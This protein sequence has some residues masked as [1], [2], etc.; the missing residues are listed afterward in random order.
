MRTPSFKSNA[1]APSPGTLRCTRIES[2]ALSAQ[3]KCTHASRR[4]SSEGIAP[5][6]QRLLGQLEM[7]LELA[8]QV[9]V[10]APASYRA[11]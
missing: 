7:R 9:V 10:G 1:N 4:A 5:A 8:P 2:R 3:P 6:A 11:P